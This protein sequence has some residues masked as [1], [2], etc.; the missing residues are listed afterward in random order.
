MGSSSTISRELKET[1]KF[2]QKEVGTENMEEDAVSTS[3]QKRRQDIELEEV[4]VTALPD[5][6][7]ANDDQEAM[8][9]EQPTPSPRKTQ[10]VGTKRKRAT[11]RLIPCT[12]CVRSVPHAQHLTRNRR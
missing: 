2:V 9:V 5:V 7:H 1:Q 4:N 3:I 6:E 11:V 10:L 8:D 12:R